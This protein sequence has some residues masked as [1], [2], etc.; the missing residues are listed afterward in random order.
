MSFGCKHSCSGPRRG[1]DV[2][3]G[4]I[5]PHIQFEKDPLNIFLVNVVRVYGRTLNSVDSKT[6]KSP[7]TLFSDIH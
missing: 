7:N 6:I 5:Y 2:S 1:S 3:H 4:G